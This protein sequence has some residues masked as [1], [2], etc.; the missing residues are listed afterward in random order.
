M[1]KSLNDNMTYLLGTELCFPD[2]CG[3]KCTGAESTWIVKVLEK[4]VVNKTKLPIRRQWCFHVHKVRSIGHVKSNLK[5]RWTVAIGY[6]L[7]RKDLDLRNQD[8]SRLQHSIMDCAITSDH[9][10]HT[11]TAI[12]T[13]KQH[14][15]THS[16]I[17]FSLMPPH[18][19]LYVPMRMIS[20][21]AESF[22]GSLYD[23]GGP[24]SPPPTSHPS[25][26]VDARN[27]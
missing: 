15:D 26:F 23:F 12:P 6:Y 13:M 5:L 24:G 22:A 21:C 9:M 7:G 20:T 16:M 11:C 2:N 27:S 18:S 1:P 19:G 8:F 10:N 17:S 4:L 3:M 25:S 14:I